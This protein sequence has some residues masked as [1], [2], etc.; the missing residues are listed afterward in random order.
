MAENL[1]KICVTVVS[2][3]PRSGTSMMMQM[4]AAGGMPVLSDGTRASDPDNPQGYFELEAVKRIAAD[5]HWLTGA[6]E[7]AVKVVHLLLPSL[8]PGH[9]YRV[10]FMNRDL[11]EVLASQEAM[12]RR[13]G[14]RGA[15][16]SPEQLARTFESQ[17]RRVR[18]WV[19]EQPHFSILDVPYRQVI[20]DPAAEAA[21]VN[22]F[23]GGHLDVA[24]MAAAVDPSLYRRRAGMV[25]NDL[26]PE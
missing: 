20:E 17:L 14:R 8:P 25:D 5:S 11:R 13:L 19:A 2:G 16:L 3:L 21:R 6:A 7:K 26:P 18:Q 22:R 4:L 9:E 23:L 15:D 24:R 1:G 10:V 12:L